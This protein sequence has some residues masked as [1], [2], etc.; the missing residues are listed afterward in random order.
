MQR[1]AE[2]V[3][4]ETGSGSRVLIQSSL[5]ASLRG[6]LDGEWGRGGCD[7]CGQAC[8]RCETVENQH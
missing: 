8:E 5:R 3:A 4:G 1:S 7:D 6:A 2:A